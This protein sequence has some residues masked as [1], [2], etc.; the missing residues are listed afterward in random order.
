MRAKQ[1]K[2]RPMK[3]SGV[4]SDFLISFKGVFTIKH[5]QTLGSFNIP[6]NSVYS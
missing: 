1:A 3:K 2:I 4:E 5:V 6:F